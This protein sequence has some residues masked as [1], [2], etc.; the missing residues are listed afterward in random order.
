MDVIGL[1]P[2]ISYKEGLGSITKS[3]WNRKNKKVSC[4]LKMVHGRVFIM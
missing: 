3:L 4:A 1:Y 2:N